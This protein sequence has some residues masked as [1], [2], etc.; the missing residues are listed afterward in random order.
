MAGLINQSVDGSIEP[1]W[2]FWPIT[3]HHCVLVSSGA[4]G[5]CLAFRVGLAHVR[6]CRLSCHCWVW[7]VASPECPDL[8]GS[9][10]CC[11]AQLPTARRVSAVGLFGW[12]FWQD[13]GPFRAPRGGSNTASWICLR[14]EPGAECRGGSH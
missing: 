2:L 10:L 14:W 12:C 7:G 3:T 9:G 13:T 5:V 8:P 11:L 1:C 4:A 6:C